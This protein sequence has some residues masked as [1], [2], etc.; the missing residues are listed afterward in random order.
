MIRINSIIDTLCGLI[1][2]RQAY[3]TS[4]LAIAESLTKSESGLYYQDGHPLLTLTNVVSLAPDFANTHW[5]DYVANKG[6]KEGN[7]VKSDEKLYKA[8]QDVPAG[9]SPAGDTE[10]VYWGTTSPFSEW[11]EAKTRA[12]VQK[13]ITRYY[14]E[15]MAKGTARSLLESKTLF[16]QAGRL[17]DTEAYGH[18]LVGMEIVP[19]RSNGVVTQIDKIGLQF[20][21]PCSVTLHLMHSSQSAPLRSVEL[22]YTKNGGSLQWFTLEEPLYLPY[23]SSDT[24]AGGSYYLVYE[25]NAN[26][27]AVIKNRDWSAAPCNACSRTEYSSYLAWSKWL[28]VHP[29]EVVDGAY[30]VGEMWDLE[31]NSYTYKSNHGINLSVSVVCDL[32][33][34]IVKHRLE[35]VD[36]ILKSVAVDFLREFVYNP[37]VRTNRNSLNVSKPD[38]MM[39][40]DGNPE[41]GRVGLSAELD[42]AYKALNFNFAGINRVCQPCN[43]HGIR[44]TTT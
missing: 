14:N 9:N 35:F 43:N 39:Q 12:Y 22:Q 33:D 7:V 23:I 29:F 37:N 26:A 34:F 20:N 18:K 1:G 4:T 25:Q 17:M 31:D 11:L 6:Y 36:L 10:H 15:R 44:Y 38:L 41:L 27:L 24:D 5:Q 42:K 16:D 21:A 13:A 40:L 32:T 8:K 30:T 2:W 28:E 19:V 3:D